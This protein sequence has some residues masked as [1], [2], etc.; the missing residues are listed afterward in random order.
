MK[1]TIKEK[2]DSMT[3]NSVIKNANVLSYNMKAYV[4]SIPRKI[5]FHFSEKNKASKESH[6]F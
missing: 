1:N 5:K 4:S 3:T 2:V 6:K